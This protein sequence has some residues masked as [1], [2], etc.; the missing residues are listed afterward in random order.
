MPAVPFTPPS[1]GFKKVDIGVV[2]KDT[3]YIHGMINAY[4]TTHGLAVEIE[5]EVPLFVKQARERIK[6]LIGIIADLRREL[7]DAKEE[8]IKANQRLHAV[9]YKEFAEDPTEWFKDYENIVMSA[10]AAD[11]LPSPPP[12]DT[13]A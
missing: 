9:L 7:Y 3:K 6:S 10:E 1:D 4:S 2:E 12:D 13:P 11:K 5:K 8:V